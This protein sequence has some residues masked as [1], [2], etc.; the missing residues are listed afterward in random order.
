[1]GEVYRFKVEASPGCQPL[2]HIESPQIVL[3]PR[4]GTVGQLAIADVESLGVRPVERRDP[5]AGTMYLLSL[6]TNQ[7]Q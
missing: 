6:N 5:R 1:M 2:A 3:T 7:A 4:P